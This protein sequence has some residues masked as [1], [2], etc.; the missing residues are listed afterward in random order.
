MTNEVQSS[1]AAPNTD[2]VGKV[3]TENENDTVSF[4]SYDKA[5]KKT[6]T[7]VERAQSAETRLALLEQEKMESEGKIQELYE[8]EK[9]KSNEFAQRYNVANKKFALK[10]VDQTVARE[11]ASRG[12]RNVDDALILLKHKGYDELSVSED[13]EVDGESMKRVLDSFEKDKVDYFTRKEIKVNDRPP[14]MDSFKPKSNDTSKMTAK[15]LSE[16]IQ[17]KYS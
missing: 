4:R 14:K 2:D 16:F 3:N 7:A 12:C 10:T 11:L 8:R 1:D 13:Y 17:N 5:I 6:K 9:Q 15:E